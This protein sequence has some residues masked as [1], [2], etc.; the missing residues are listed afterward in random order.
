MPSHSEVAVYADGSVVCHETHP[1]RR[2]GEGTQKYYCKYCHAAHA[3]W[4]EMN[5]DDYQVTGQTVVLCGE[6]EHT[7]VLWR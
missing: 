4:W 2:L 7:S 6:C 3:N 1:V 5:Q